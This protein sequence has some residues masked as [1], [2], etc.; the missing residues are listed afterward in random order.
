MDGPKKTFFSFSLL[1]VAVVTTAG[2]GFNQQSKFQMSFLP[3]APHGT[4]A[5]ASDI[6]PAPVVTPNAYLQDLPAFLLTPPATPLKRGAAD[7]CIRAAQQHF[8]AGKKFYQA[9]DIPNARAEFDAAV[10]TMLQ[11]P[12][13]IP[14]DRAECEQKLDEMVEAI[15]R[16][17]LSGMGAAI[18]VTDS[19]FEKAPLEDILQMTFPVD[20]KLKDRVRDQMAATVSQLPL[21]VNDAVLGYIN[22]FANRGHETLLTGYQR[23][24]LYRPMIQRILSEEGVPQELIHLAQAESGFIPH[25]LSRKAAVGMWQFVA[26]RGQQYGLME[27]RYTDDR[28]DPEMATRAAARHLHDLYNEFGDWYL[29]IA[30]YNC[31]PGVVEKAVERTGYADFW[32]LRNRG[33][34]PAETTNYVPIILALTIMEK[35]GAEYG[36]SDSIL[37]APLEYDTI[38]V[39]GLTSLKLVSDITGMPVSQLAW[40]NPALIKGM[41]PDGYSLHVPKGTGSQVSAALQRFPV[42]RRASWRYHRV[43]GDETLAEI[44]RRYG[45]STS[46]IMA[47]NN[48]AAA[49]VAEGDGLIIPAVDR[50]DAPS[51]R[52]AVRTMAR[53]GV[54]SQASR[55]T[56]GTHRVAAVARASRVPAAKTTAAAKSARK[57]A[58]ML[59]SN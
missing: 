12:V 59:A 29:A 53:Q 24:G 44:G 23:S 55:T 3:P 30:A 49:Q 15:H 40:L 1:A 56:P 39:S 19:R 10:D 26:F 2:C 9:K 5:E 13:G 52:P 18:G 57:N 16:Y 14:A 4:D 51:R 47:A 17:D 46:S 8:E 27:T 54:R 37:D 21:S 28:M 34:L 22:Y 25:A 35:N 45:V 33:V 50:E 36:L 31:G 11:A 6:P 48:L 20:P 38:R 41:V 42:E 32:E 7:S 58:V 43:G